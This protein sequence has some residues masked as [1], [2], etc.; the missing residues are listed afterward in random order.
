M[1]DVNSLSKEATRNKS[2][3]LEGAYSVENLLAQIIS[4]HF[5]PTDVI[6]RQEFEQM[7]LK[8][9]WC[10]FAAKRKVIESII[11]K[12][13]LLVGKDFSDFQK[14]LKGVMSYRNAFTHGKMIYKDD[15]IWLRYFEGEPREVELSD[16]YL[17]KVEKCLL[18][19]YERTFNLF[20]TI[21]PESSEEDQQE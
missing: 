4:I 16:E 1:E 10:T 14:L 17:K 6:R 21:E 9:D 7:V 20:H 5:H 8:S 11:K 18:D 12:H 15:A 13:S 19:G 3:V 2:K